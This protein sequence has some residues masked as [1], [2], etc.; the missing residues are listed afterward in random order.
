M[1]FLAAGTL[2]TSAA[3]ALAAP[4]PGHGGGR[5]PGYGAGHG[6]GLEPGGSTTETGTTAP[7]TRR[8]HATRVVLC[9]RAGPRHWVRI[10]VSSRSVPAHL[11][12]GDHAP[13]PGQGC[14]APSPTTST[15]TTVETTTTAD[16]SDDDTASG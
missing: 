7:V 5:P 10:V 12:R 14:V 6:P 3:I 13:L 2:G 1:L 8:S 16:G 11:R 15:T 4:P 9:H